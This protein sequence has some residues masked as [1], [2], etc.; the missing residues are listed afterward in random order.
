MTA[1]YS[2]HFSVDWWNA[3]VTVPCFMSYY[4]DKCHNEYGVERLEHRI[5]GKA[6]AKASPDE[7]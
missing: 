3:M 4:S 6:L 7:W 5:S 2:S 1:R